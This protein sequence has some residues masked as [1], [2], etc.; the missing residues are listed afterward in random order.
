MEWLKV[1]SELNLYSKPGWGLDLLRT[2]IVGKDRFD[3]AFRQY[4]KNWAF[5]H[6]TPIDFFRSMDNGTGED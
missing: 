5:K 4:I 2:Q 1:T 3:Y 6:P